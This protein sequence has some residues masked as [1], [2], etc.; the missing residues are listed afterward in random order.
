[1]TAISVPQ[2]QANLFVS[3]WHRHHKPAQGDLFR[4]AAID[5]DG[6]MVGVVQVGR[7]V[8]R[9][10]NGQ[11]VCEV[12]RL[13]TDGTRNA[14]SFLYAAAA[15]KAR[16]MGYGKIITYILADEPGTSLRAAGWTHEADTDADSWNRPSRPRID[17]APT[18]PKQRWAKE[19]Q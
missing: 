11:N 12:T 18:C 14:C 8:A 19:L 16:R 9:G 17:K 3:L 10:F 1:M 4:I 5:A 15:R 13:C 6:L 7:P 2:H